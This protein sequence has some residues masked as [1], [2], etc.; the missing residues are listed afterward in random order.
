ME[1]SIYS[2]D[3]LLRLL[4]ASSRSKNFFILNFFSLFIRVVEE[5][6]VSYMLLM[7]FSNNSF[8]RFLSSEVF[9]FA[10]YNWAKVE[11]MNVIE[12]YVTEKEVGPS[13]ILLSISQMILSSLI[14]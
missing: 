14:V 11:G 4:I 5:D 8:D 9:M 3:S 1:E 2:K 6:L 12:D 13:S 10:K 7:C